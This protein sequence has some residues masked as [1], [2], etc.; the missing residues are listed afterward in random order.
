MG[1]CTHT[2]GIPY[3][4]YNAKVTS[5]LVGSSL[6]NSDKLPHLGV[7]CSG[8]SCADGAPHDVVIEYAPVNGV[9]MLTVWVDPT[10]ITGTHTPTSS[11]PKAINIAYNIDST[12]NP[13]TGLA[14]CPVVDKCGDEAQDLK[15]PPDSRGWDS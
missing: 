10:F 15:G 7:K 2:H 11:S 14:L 3:T 4:I 1:R 9:F 12:Q 5:C 13:A 6:N 8:N